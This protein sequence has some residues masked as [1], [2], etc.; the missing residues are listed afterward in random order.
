MLVLAHPPA[1]HYTLLTQKQLLS[2]AIRLDDRH[3]MLRIPLRQCARQLQSSP[4]ATLST[5][6]ASPARTALQTC[7]RPLALSQRRKYAIAAEETSKGVVREP[8]AADAKF[9]GATANNDRIGRQRL[10]PPGQHSQLCR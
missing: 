10:V 5:L 1:L 7:R 2:S 8:C 4:R 3:T 6:A 9:F